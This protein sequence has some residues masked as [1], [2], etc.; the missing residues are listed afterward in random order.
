MIDLQGEVYSC[1]SLGGCSS[2][3]GKPLGRLTVTNVTGLP[4][5]VSFNID[6]MV[7]LRIFDT[8]TTTTEYTL[9][10]TLPGSTTR[11][12]TVYSWIGGPSNPYPVDARSGDL[13]ITVTDGVTLHQARLPWVYLGL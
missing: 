2:P 11:N 1:G 13:V 3:T 5:T 12:Y 8:D 9:I 6:G 4:Y 10:N 7:H